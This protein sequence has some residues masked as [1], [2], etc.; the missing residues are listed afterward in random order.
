MGMAPGRVLLGYIL[1]PH[2][3][4]GWRSH[5]AFPSP[6]ED[7]TDGAASCEATLH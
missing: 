6:P 7:R 4:E 2:V 5:T 1:Y 3:P